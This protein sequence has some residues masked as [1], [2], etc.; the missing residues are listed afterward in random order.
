MV[1]PLGSLRLPERKDEEV[2][3]IRL[4]DGRV[5]ARTRRELEEAQA[6]GQQ[7]GGGSAQ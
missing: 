6:Q 3:L 5:V 4:P 7:Q 1:E 2:V